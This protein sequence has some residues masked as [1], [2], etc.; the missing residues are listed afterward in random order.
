[1]TQSREDD[2]VKSVLTVTK[3]SRIVEPNRQPV[4]PRSSGSG[5]A[6]RLTGGK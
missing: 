1:M 3:A 2:G 5:W 6:Q 4:G